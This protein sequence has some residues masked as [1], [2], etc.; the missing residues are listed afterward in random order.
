VYA[1]GLFWQAGGVPVNNIAMWDGQAWSA[2]GEGIE[3]QVYALAAAGK[4]LY[5]GG[6]FLH[7]GGIAANNIARWDGNEWHALGKGVNKRVTQIVANKTDVYVGG[8]FKLAGGSEIQSLA[9]WDGSEWHQVMADAPSSFTMALN[10]ENL[11]IGARNTLRRWN[12]RRWSEW[13]LPGQSYITAL[14]FRGADLFISGQLESSAHGV[15][16][17]ARWRGGKLDPLGSGVNGSV[18]MLSAH[19]QDIYVRGYFTLAGNKPSG[20][21]GIWHD[22]APLT[23]LLVSPLDN[24]TVKKKSVWLRWILSANAHTYDVQVKRHSKNGKL[25]VNAFTSDTEYR[26]PELRPDTTFLWRVRA[27]SEVNAVEYCSS[28]SPWHRFSTKEI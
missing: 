8:S 26:T 6:H 3:Y 27:C 20:D 24:D 17:I 10:G 22:P 23:P 4:N 9:R 1:G 12:G 13:A 25:I 2:L 14:A 7:A 28:W 19:N 21:F 16:H 5:A 18:Y 11:Y 15:I